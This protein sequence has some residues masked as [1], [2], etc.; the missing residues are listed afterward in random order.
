MSHIFEQD[1]LSVVD[2][3]EKAIK[4]LSG[5]PILCIETYKVLGGFIT[6]QAMAGKNSMSRVLN[7]TPFELIPFTNDNKF[8]KVN[9]KS[10]AEMG[11]IFKNR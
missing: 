6:S 1:T 8:P 5:E 11:R 2:L 10:C 3:Q 7:R 4:K 9:K